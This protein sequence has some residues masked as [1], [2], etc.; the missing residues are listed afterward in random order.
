MFHLFP[1]KIHGWL[2]YSNT[3]LRLNYSRIWIKP[4]SQVHAFWFVVSNGVLYR[5]HYQGPLLKCLPGEETEYVI[6]EIHERCCEDHIGMISLARKNLVAG[7]WWPTMN[8][9]SSKI[10]QACEGCHQHGNFMHNPI[11]SLKPIRASCPFDQW[12]L[13]IIGP[14]PIASKRNSFSW[15]L[16]NIQNGWRNLQSG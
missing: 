10:V 4:R 8:F 15:L 7:F 13:N 11:F 16:I 3:S 5:R 14:F 9:D 1:G 2:L 6:R 12:G